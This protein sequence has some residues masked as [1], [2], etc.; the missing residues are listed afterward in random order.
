MLRRLS[1][2]ARLVLGVIVLAAIGLA[3]ADVAT[4][5]SLRSF[6]FDRTDRT[7]ATGGGAFE[8]EHDGGPGPRGGSLFVQLRSPDGTQVLRTEP[9]E[10]FPGEDQPA[11]PNLP[12]TVT[13]PLDKDT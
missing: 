6:L 10:T 3:A 13:L 4:Y 5:A 12:T 11:Q 1:L 2:R 8:H 7:L 9:A